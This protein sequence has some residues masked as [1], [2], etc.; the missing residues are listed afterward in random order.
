MAHISFFDVCATEQG[1]APSRLGGNRG[2]ALFCSI[3]NF[4]GEM[5][6]HEIANCKG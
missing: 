6:Q 4:F 3:H 2:S 5:T 1:R